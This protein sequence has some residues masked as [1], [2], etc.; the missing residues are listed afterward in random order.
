LAQRFA[1]LLELGLAFRIDGGV[2]EAR[3]GFRAEP[4]AP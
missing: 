1:E 4:S 3:L 2:F